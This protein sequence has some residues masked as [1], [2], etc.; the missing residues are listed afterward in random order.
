[1]AKFRPDMENLIQASGAVVAMG[2]YNTTTELLASRQPALLVPRVE[3]RVEQLIRAER[4]AEMGLIDMIHPN[5]VTPQ[6]IRHKV[7]DLLEEGHRSRVRVQVDLSGAERAVQLV[8][9]C[10]GLG[11]WLTARV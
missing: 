4:L 11:R 2:G 9:S 3:P 7:E 10:A 6:L 5:D 8:C 1:V